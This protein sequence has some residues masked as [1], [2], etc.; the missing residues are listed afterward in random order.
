[1]SIIFPV[2][3]TFSPLIP[4]ITYVIIKPKRRKWLTTLIAYSVVYIPFIAYANYLQL[5]VTPNIIIFVFITIMTFCCFG[6]IIS[7]L[8]NS[9]LF[10]FIN[11]IA[12]GIVTIFSITNALWWEKLKLYN[13]YSSSLSCIILICYCLYYYWYQ[14]Q[15]PKDLFIYRQPSFWMITGIFIYCGGNFFVF[16]NYGELC[17]QAQSLTNAG[18]REQANKLWGFA[19]LIWIVADFLILFTNIFFAKAIL[20]SR[21]K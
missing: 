3:E 6:L 5:M 10:S 12:I 15:N 11:Y 2:I 16:S 13:S 18:L 17:R 1:M 4:L 14:I 19:G 20:C 9:K 21:Y 8:L 7:F